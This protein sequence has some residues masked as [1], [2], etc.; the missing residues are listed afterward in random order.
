M[1]TFNTLRVIFALV[2]TGM[3]VGAFFSFQS[4]STFLDTATAKPGVVTDLIRS[5]SGDSNAYYPIVRFEDEQGRLTEFRSSS[6]SN[7]PSYSPGETVRVLF[8]PDEPESARID[9]FFS[10][11]GATLIVGF[12]GGV[13]FLIGAGMFVVPA[14]RNGG[15]AKLR[16]T[17]QRVQ[18]IFQGVEKNKMIEM[19]GKSPYQIVCQWQNPV[20][21][22]IHVFRSDNLWFDPSEHIQSESI[23]VYINPTNPKRYWV[24][25]SFLPKMAA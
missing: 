11:W 18:G 24:D 6:G 15:A 19:N 5:R 16:E 21:S 7:P 17:G 4:T 10:L 2:G 14:V 9:G 13:F 22:D 8:T 25:T 20:T 23:P 12:L 3:L 1:K